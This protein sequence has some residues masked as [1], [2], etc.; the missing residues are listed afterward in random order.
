MK[1]LVCAK[2]VETLKEEGKTELYIDEDAIVTPS[3]RDAADSL[4]V[5]FSYKK[6]CGGGKCPFGQPGHRQQSDL[7][8]T[9]GTVG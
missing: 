6:G 8:G 5:T 4:G 2:D 9:E 7:H 1:Q 3:A